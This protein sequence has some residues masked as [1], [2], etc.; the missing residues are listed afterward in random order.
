MGHNEVGCET[1][2][3][4][5]LDNWTSNRWRRT[6]IGAWL[7]GPDRGATVVAGEAGAGQPAARRLERTLPVVAAATAA[8]VVPFVLR[9]AVMRA[10]TLRPAVETTLALFCLSAAWLLRARFMDSGRLR[11]LLLV[12]VTLAFGLM[13]LSLNALPAALNVG[14]GRYLAAAG[15]WGQ[16]V[17]AAM[18][19]AAAAVPG[20]RLAAQRG[21]S[22][23]MGLLL[24]LAPT[25]VGLVG[26]LV[27]RS[28]GLRLSAHGGPAAETVLLV[29]VTGTTVL[30]TYAGSALARENL[31]RPDAVV[32]LLA[33]A[34]LLLAGAALCRLTVRSLPTGEV[35]TGTAMR[36]LA[37]ALLLCAAF[38]LERRVRSR[39][40]RAAALAER[41]R[42]ARDLHDGI[43][44]DLA[45][46][47]A[48]GDQIAA[49]MGEEH[50]VVVAARRALAVSRSTISDL[51]DPAGATAS[52]ALDAVAQELRDRFDV[53]IAVHTQIDGHL[54]LDVGEHLSRIAREAIANAARHGQA[55]NVLVSLRRADGGVALRVVDDGCGIPTGD[56]GSTPEGF[57]IRSMRERAGAL[58]GHMTVRRAP[59][60]GTELEV[61]LP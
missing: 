49:E 51:S 5:L 14:N 2:G 61:V 16:L 32:A 41:R 52:E 57:G 54:P 20:D 25:A 31:R 43:A 39:V 56:R 19:A 18:F 7:A 58:G 36:V 38:V 30:L 24:G 9:G 27:T 47:A 33:S 59:K 6:R 35:G 1:R 28:L 8:L 10:P 45:F 3:G 22:A 40:A 46:I 53:A 13:T 17:V 60:G 23:R 29:L 15:L 50:P 26:G 55:R 12:S 21:H 34:V 48:H 44:Q 37:A 42:V 11:D 4:V